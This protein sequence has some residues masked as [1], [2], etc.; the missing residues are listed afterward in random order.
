MKTILWLFSMFFAVIP[1]CYFAVM[2]P[3]PAHKNEGFGG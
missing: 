2:M 1:R 3:A